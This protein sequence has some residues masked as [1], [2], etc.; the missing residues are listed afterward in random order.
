VHECRIGALIF[1][2]GMG[3]GIAWMLFGYHHAI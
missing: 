3:F 1:A 2:F